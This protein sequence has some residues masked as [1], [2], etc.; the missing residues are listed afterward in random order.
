MK[1]LEEDCPQYDNL[2]PINSKHF[3]E[4]A[5]TSE[6]KLSKFRKKNQLKENDLIFLEYNFEP[7]AKRAKYR[8]V[9]LKYKVSCMLIVDNVEGSQD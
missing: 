3:A 2:Y 9:I 1:E 4:S 5:L 7:N 6:R 8:D